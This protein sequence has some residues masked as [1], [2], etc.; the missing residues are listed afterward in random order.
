MVEHYVGTI[1]GEINAVSYA[2]QMLYCP[3]PNPR[4]LALDTCV[5][6]QKEMPKVFARTQKVM[7]LLCTASTASAE[8]SGSTLAIC[9]L[10]NRSTKKLFWRETYKRYSQCCEMTY[11]D[12]L[13]TYSSLNEGPFCC[14]HAAENRMGND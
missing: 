8:R 4:T 9:M 10:R 2:S 1:C 12:T 5:V 14:A 6:S 7:R 13:G 3:D 11:S